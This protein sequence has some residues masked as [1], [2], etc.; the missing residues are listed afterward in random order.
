MPVVTFR[1]RIALATLA[2]AATFALAWA[3]PLDGGT[4]DSNVRALGRL[5]PLIVHFPIVLLLLTP[6]F[7]LLG[8]ARPTLREA[9]GVI[10]G[11][12]MVS[13]VA[14][15]FAGLVLARSGGQEGA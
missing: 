3:M 10:L 5:H 13:A 8:R 4:H 7:E 14:A 15:V 9:A 2:L 12:A 11:F 1:R 6:V